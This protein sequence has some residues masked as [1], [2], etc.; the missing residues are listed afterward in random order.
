MC[1]RVLVHGRGTGLDGWDRDL[2]LQCKP[3]LID[4][5][6]A[7]LSTD[8]GTRLPESQPFI[9]FPFRASS[10]FSLAEV[11]FI[12]CARKLFCSLFSFWVILCASSSS[13]SSSSFLGFGPRKLSVNTGRKKEKKPS[14][15]PADSW[16]TCRRSI[17]A[18]FTQKGTRFCQSSLSAHQQQAIRHAEQN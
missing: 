9:F 15:G 10:F 1:V 3:K 17:Q 11:V 18:V 6:S 5:R 13:S 16:L 14:D 2:Q 4:T 8:G 12:L 7:T